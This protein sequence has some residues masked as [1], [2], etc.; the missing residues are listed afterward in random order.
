VGLR[1]AFIITAIVDLTGYAN[2]AYI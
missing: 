2:D 1:H